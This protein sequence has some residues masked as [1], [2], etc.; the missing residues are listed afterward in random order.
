MTTMYSLYFSLLALAFLNEISSFVVNVSDSSLRIGR[1][2]RMAPTNI[3]LNYV[4]DSNLTFNK[5]THSG[6]NY[7]VIV[8]INTF[9]NKNRRNW[10]EFL[11]NQLQ[12]AN[13]T[14]II[15]YRYHLLTYA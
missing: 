4:S 13:A 2:S 7:K 14:G 12:E 3:T 8:A 5:T 9:V 11:A 15:Y 1:I 10:H 6:D